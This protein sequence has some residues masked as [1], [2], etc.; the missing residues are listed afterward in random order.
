MA[1]I[2]LVLWLVPDLALARG[3]KL[4]DLP[5]RVLVARCGG[6]PV[7][8]DVWVREHLGAAQRVL[9]PH[10]IR[11]RPSLESFRPRSCQAVGRAGRNALASH[12]PAA[13]V[14]VLVVERVPDLDLPG[15]DLMGVHWRYS[16]TDEGLAG[17]RYILL[18]ARARP[19]VLAH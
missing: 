10:R 11:L 18:T 1:R 19:P 8:D 17:R 2:V 3:E 15:Y 5:L 4:F 13:G 6:R 9:A 12:V 16:G 7:R 14:T